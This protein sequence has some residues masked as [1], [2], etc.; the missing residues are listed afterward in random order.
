MAE[1]YAELAK[2]RR[3]GRAIHLSLSRA[4]AYS[5]RS[6][7]PKCSPTMQCGRSYPT[8]MR[9]EKMN[10]LGKL[11]WKCDSLRP[12]DH[13]GRVGR[14]GSGHRVDPFRGSP[15]RVTWPYL[16]REWLTSVDH[17]R[18]GHHVHHTGADHAAARLCRR[19]HDAWGRQA[20]SQQAAAQGYLAARAFR[21]DLLG[22][23]HES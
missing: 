8:S 20:G 12:A 1:L 5:T 11:N 18:I 19:P 3:V 13:H 6:G 17:K 9:A 23:W 7:S 14:N 21:P 10:L 2:P 16:W 4:R 15:S 22:A